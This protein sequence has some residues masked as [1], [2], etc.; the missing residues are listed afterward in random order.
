MNRL[1]LQRGEIATDGTARLTDHRHRHI[2]KV[3]AG[4]P[5]DALKVGII[6]GRCGQAIIANTNADETRLSDIVCEQLPPPKL[7]LTLLLALPRPKAARRICRTVAELGVEQLVL[8]NS[9]RV[10]KSYWQS[11]LLTQERILGYFLEGLEQ[12]GDTVLPT[13]QVEKRF[14]P[15]VEDRLPAMVGGR[16]A[17]IAHPYAGAT[18][19]TTSREPSI[20]AVG[21]EGGFIPYEV[22][23]LEQAGMCGLSLGPRILRVETAVPTLLAKL[24]P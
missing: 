11:P 14:K 12:A 16:R 24:F 5:G 3:L 15:F 21:P 2:R 19:A 18:K 1:L 6:N 13:L 9:Y 7:P 4:Q 10:E 17:L 20:L 8:L 23:K 22:E